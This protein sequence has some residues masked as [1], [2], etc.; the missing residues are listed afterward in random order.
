MTPRI[1]RMLGFCGLAFFA[2]L[3]S[4]LQAQAAAAAE[5]PAAE[6]FFRKPV[7]SGVQLSPSGERVALL[8]PGANG[9]V[10]LAVVEMDHWDKP[11][12][13]A[14]FSD[15]DLR[16]VQWVN[17]NRLIFDVIDFQRGI[18]EQAG[19]G[20]WAVNADG[21]QLRRLIN[22][23]GD[24]VREAS[25]IASRT[26]EWN[27]RLLRV[28]RDGSADIVVERL[29]YGN[30]ELKSSVPLRLNTE[31]GT[32]QALVD[33]APPGAQGWLVDDRGVARVAQAV[34]DGSTLMYWRPD[35]KS[36]WQVV[37]RE[38]NL[39]M[40]SLEPFGVSNRGDV[41]VRTA[42]PGSAKLWALYRFLPAERK[43]EDKPLVSLDGF[44]FTGSLVFDAEGKRLLGVHFNADATG[45]AWIDPGM[46]EVQKQVDSAMPN[47]INMLLCSRC[48]K[49][50][51]V[52]VIAHADRVSPYYSVYDRQAKRLLPV[53]SSRPWLEKLPMAPRDFVRIKAR[54]GL[55]LPTYIT[56]PAG[57]GPWPTVVLVH[58]GP[59]V[60]GGHWEWSPDSQFLASRGYLVVETDFRGSEGYGA[61]HLRAG[62][63]QWGLKMQ[64]DVADATEWAIQQ[65]LAKRDRICIAGASYGGYATLMGLLR[66][67]ELYR[68]GVNWVG[69]TDI[70]LMYSISWSDMSNSWKRYGMPEMIG[71]RQKDAEQLKATSPVAQAERIRQPILMA[72]GGN[73][74]RVPIEHGRKFR[75]AVQQHNKDVE[76]IEYPTE[77]HGWLTTANQVDFWT[78]VERFLDRNIGKDAGGA[79]ATTAS[80][81]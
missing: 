10:M 25:A 30:D 7:I 32:V 34:Q 53:G 50:R 12:F 24:F 2:I 63:K 39:Y 38:A 26:L 64:D 15:I 13:V 14:G 11:R 69:V 80:S 61:T 78:R 8:T 17:D 18:G 35:E 59:W 22:P 49:S 19:P 43:L 48:D 81:N 52:L 75:S 37:H 56:K 46:A 65:G 70:E 58:G 5:P 27:H 23:R 29:Y 6:L 1:R 16:S 60:R 73:D 57:K 40:S 42:M 74:H 79:G 28:L 47:T 66:Y 31:T 41:F 20:L 44:D 45:S 55:E 33:R 3:L 71:D 54:D 36:E 76:W 9:R 62:F 77:G 68:C 51:Y 67:P 21:S 72:Y 4:A